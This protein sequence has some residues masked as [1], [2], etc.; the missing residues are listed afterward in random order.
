MRAV[1]RRPP[2]PRG[3]TRPPPQTRSPGSH[4]PIA[5]PAPV[6]REPSVSDGVDALPRCEEPKARCSG[7]DTHLVLVG[8]LKAHAQRRALRRKGASQRR[9]RARSS[10]GRSC[11][12][13]H[14]GKQLRAVVA[15]AAGLRTRNAEDAGARLPRRR[16][17]LRCRVA[18]A[19]ASA[20]KRRGSGSERAHA[21]IK[22]LAQAPSAVHSGVSAGVA[23]E[24]LALATKAVRRVRVPVATRVLWWQPPAPR[25][26]ARTCV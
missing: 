8:Q 9:S 16:A 1:R 5:A 3:P 6:H 17:L 22:Q 14:V 20:S 12:A 4:P 15:R 23:V 25:N 21:K 2:P 7:G 18:T 13:H 11:E 10:E 24:G 26:Q 19:A